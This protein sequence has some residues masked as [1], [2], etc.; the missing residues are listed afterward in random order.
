MYQ[1]SHISYLCTYIVCHTNASTS[2]LYSTCAS[3]R[4]IMSSER[5]T[6]NQR[7]GN[8]RPRASAS[9]AETGTPERVSAR[10]AALPRVAGAL[11]FPGAEAFL[12]H[13]PRRLTCMPQGSLGRTYEVSLLRI[14]ICKNKHIISPSISRTT[15]N[16]T[17][18]HN[19]LAKV[20]WYCC[21]LRLAPHAV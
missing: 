15:R 2:F 20:S 1:A 12:R 21:T 13:P 19:V 5:Y 3:G 11:P 17:A 6:C 7:R 8:S 14:H 4:Y 9:I 18:V 16:A 10:S